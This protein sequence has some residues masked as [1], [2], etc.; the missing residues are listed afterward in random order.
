M[1]RAVPHAVSCP[2]GD[3]LAILDSRDNRYY[4]LNPVGALIW[5]KLAGWETIDRIVHEVMTAFE[6]SEDVARQDTVRLIGELEGAGLVE[7]A[8]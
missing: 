5:S 1:Q 8:D 2:L 4:S 6:V 7:S 3:G